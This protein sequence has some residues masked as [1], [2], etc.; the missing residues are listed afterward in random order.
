MKC[1]HYEDNIILF[2]YNELSERE[3]KKLNDHLNTC[4]NCREFLKEN[5]RMLSEI[6]AEENSVFD[7]DWDGYWLG[8]RK[9][10]NRRTETKWRLLP[11][12]SKG[13]SFAMSALILIA[14]IT[15][16]KFFLSSPD[17]LETVTREDKRGGNLLLVREYFED[18]KPVMLD[19]ANYTVNGDN[20]NGAPVD[21]EIVIGML[22]KARLLRRHISTDK[23]PYLSALLEDLEMILT[24]IKNASPGEKDSLRS[25]Q[26]MIRDK[27][28]PLKIDLFKNKVTRSEKI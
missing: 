17:A 2:I 25:L 18:V 11:F 24:E 4:E 13:L 16:G 8:I 14:G 19:Y 1:R 28:I 26:G 22:D 21:R 3:T 5:K 20:G 23:D 7:P 6:P 15:I 10:M 12:S 27:M 9:E